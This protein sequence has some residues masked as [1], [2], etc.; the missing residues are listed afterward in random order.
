MPL[1]G[2]IAR[3]GGNTRIGTVIGM[4]LVK[5]VGMTA[6]AD[7]NTDTVATMMPSQ[8]TGTDI[9]DIRPGTTRVKMIMLVRPAVS[10]AS[11]RPAQ[12]G[13]Q[14]AHIHTSRILPF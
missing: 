4:A 13:R 9:V 6:L 5:T 7:I 14:P 2:R 3:T 12:K 10:G 1:I 8:S 11:D